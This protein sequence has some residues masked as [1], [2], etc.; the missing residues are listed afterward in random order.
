MVRTIAGGRFDVGM[1]EKIVER[2]G[3]IPL[4]V[5][6]LTQSLL[7][8]GSDSGA[9]SFRPAGADSVWRQESGPRAGYRL[10]HAEA[11]A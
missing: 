8:S 3:G 10:R 11:S 5:E 9:R 2:A 7:E 1:I 4:Y 6:E